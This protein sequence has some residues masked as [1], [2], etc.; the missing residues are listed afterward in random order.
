[1][2]TRGLLVT[3]IYNR[4]SRYRNQLPFICG[5]FSLELKIIG[6]Y[7]VTTINCKKFF[8]NSNLIHKDA[9]IFNSTWPVVTR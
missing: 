3:S 7:T 1:M 4:I 5:A 6:E 9:I 8:C 2:K